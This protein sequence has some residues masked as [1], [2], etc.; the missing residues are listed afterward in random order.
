MEKSVSVLQT[1][2]NSSQF[3]LEKAAVVVPP[4]SIQIKVLNDACCSKF[5]FSHLI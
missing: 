4:E 2:S 1:F 5:L 3:T